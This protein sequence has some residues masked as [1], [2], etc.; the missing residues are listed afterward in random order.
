M[1]CLDIVTGQLH[2]ALAAPV[3]QPRPHWEGTSEA[4]ARHP[5][6]PYVGTTAPLTGPDRSPARNSMTFASASGSTAPVKNS[7]GRIDLKSLITRR[8]EVQNPPP[9][10]QIVAVP[11]DPLAPEFPA[12]P[13]GPSTQ[14]VLVPSS[15]SPKRSIASG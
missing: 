5:H 10:T 3:H 8:S 7:G 15:T 6:P 11:A 2:G 9:V 12:Q 4:G 13:D 14:N 1:P